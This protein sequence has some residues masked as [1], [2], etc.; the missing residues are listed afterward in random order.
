MSFAGAFWP[1]I[2]NKCWRSSETPGCGAGC[3]IQVRPFKLKGCSQVY[4]V[5]KRSCWS[6][7]HPGLHACE[8]KGNS[9]DFNSLFYPKL[10]FRGIARW[11]NSAGAGAAKAGIASLD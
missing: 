1:S 6:L 8:A 2:E 3:L 11:G 5:T 10:L 9:S 4:K 7:S